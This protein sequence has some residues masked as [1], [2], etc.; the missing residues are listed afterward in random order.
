M[1]FKCQDEALF[2]GLRPHERNR[3]DD[4]DDRGE[5]QPAAKNQVCSA[6]WIAY[7]S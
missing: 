4:G 6:T 5:Q 2:E 7:R 3:G 1:A